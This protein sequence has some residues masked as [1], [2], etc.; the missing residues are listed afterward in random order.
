M[1]VYLH[2]FETPLQHPFTI[3]RGTTHSVRSLIVEIQHEGQIGYGEAT[4]HLYYDISLETQI[5]RAHV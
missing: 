4:E 2:R 3:A 5:G 1:K